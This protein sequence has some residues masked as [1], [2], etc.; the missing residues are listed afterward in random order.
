MLE[1]L[2]GL[3][4]L[5]GLVFAIAVPIVAIVLVIVRAGRNQPRRDRR[6]AWAAGSSDSG[7]YVDENGNYVPGSGGEYSG[8]YDPG[9]GGYSGH[10]GHHHGGSYDHGSTGYSSGSDSGSSSSSCG[11]G[12]SS[13]SCGG[14]S[15]SSCGGGSS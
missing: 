5:G 11:G 2:V 12:S 1:I 10:H 7:G 14:G 6:S 15:S 9:S 3:L 4:F 8:G 13:S